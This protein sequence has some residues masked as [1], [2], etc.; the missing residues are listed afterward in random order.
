MPVRVR[1]APSPT[2][3]PHVGSMRTALYNWLVARGSG[4]QFILRIEDTDVARRAEGALGQMME[5]LRW[6]GL[7]WDEGPDVG[8]PYGPYVQSQRLHLYR[9][10]A[11]QLVAAGAAY[12][13]F[14]SPEELES[15]RQRQITQ[16]RPPRY[17]G[18]CRRLTPDDAEARRSEPHVLRLRVPVS[19]ETVAQDAIRGPLRFPN[20]SLDDPVLFKTDGFPTYHLANVVDD[21][22]MQITH[23]LRG[24]EWIPST[25]WHVMLYQTLGWEPPT[26]VHLPLMLDKD[27]AKMSKRAG[28]TSV[29][30]YRRLG[31][32][33]DALLNYIAFLGW[34]PGTRQDV[35]TRQELVQSFS[36]GRLSRSPAV[37]DLDRLNWFNR[38][39]IRTLSPDEL[40][41]R[42]SPYLV[43]AYGA[44]HRAGGTDLDPDAWS[45]SL[46][47]AVKDELTCLSDIVSAS[48]FAFVGQVQP[49]PAAAQALSVPTARAV[50]KA[51]V[52]RCGSVE[53]WDH[54]SA[55]ALF[56]GLRADLKALDGLTGKQVMQPIRAALTGSLAGPCLVA[57]ANLLGKQTCI[58]RVSP[59]IR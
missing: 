13:C 34:S 53:R 50:L 27:R 28:E 10:V 7:D 2:G 58:D 14:C 25:P 46:L 40:T 56:R 47:R 31:Y 26:F 43:E 51:F 55:D 44:W 5:A 35:M 38:Q 8:G 1:F 41:Q 48:R 15:Q 19:G 37:F 12:R 30:E 39:Y 57:V 32:L 36:L 20:S 45:D 21:H 4:G 9:K 33:P 24:E 16:H 22:R 17:A 59:F 6:L 49:D 54:D 42:T 29:V 3:Q 23:V 11:D 18:T 52:E